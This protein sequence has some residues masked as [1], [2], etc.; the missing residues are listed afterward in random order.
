[1]LFIM[2]SNSIQEMPQEDSLSPGSSLPCAR[3]KEGRA[4]ILWLLLISGIVLL[5][6]AY[7]CDQLDIPTGDE[8]HYLVISQTIL[9]YHSLD[10]TKDYAHNDYKAF[11]EGPLGPFQ[12][13]SLNRWGQILPLHSIG[14]PVLW[15]IPFAI[16]GRLG[17]L[18]FMALISVLIVMTSYLLLIALGIRRNYA[19]ATSLALALASPIWI[20]SHH[21]FVEPLAALFCVY[22]V[23]VIFKERLRAWAEVSA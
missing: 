14:A 1:M 4:H 19:F 5:L 12:H 8:P 23:F 16:A 22:I 6:S 15:L 21:D 18:L 17:T 13:T 9:L 2:N 7:V 11:Y 10:V 20:Y 3:K